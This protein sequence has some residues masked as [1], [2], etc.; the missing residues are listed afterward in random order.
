MNQSSFPYN[1]DW[2]IITAE[3]YNYEKN[4]VLLIFNVA[5]N[6]FTNANNVIQY[7]IGRLKYGSLNF[8]DNAFIKV[9]FDIRGQKNT[10]AEKLK[11]NTLNL[12]KENNIVNKVSIDFVKN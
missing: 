3:G 12:L 9:I 10:E 1:L 7:V 6:G 4:E 8:P 2:G 11:A 5:I